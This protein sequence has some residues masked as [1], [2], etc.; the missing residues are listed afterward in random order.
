MALTGLERKAVFRLFHDM[1]KIP[2]APVEG[3]LTLTT[4]RPHDQ[5]NTTIYNLNDRYRGTINRR[6]VVFL[7]I[8][9]MLDRGI[10][11]GDRVGLTTVCN[12]PGDYSLRNLE[13]V[14]FGLP[15]DCA[16]ACFPVANVLIPWSYFDPE[17]FVASNKSAPV[18]LTRSPS[19]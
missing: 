6:D 11:S 9:H 8:D 4:A 14:G 17:S 16:M 1:Q 5:C 19:T 7:N 15:R 13:A 10:H 12:E 2:S 18:L 3:Q